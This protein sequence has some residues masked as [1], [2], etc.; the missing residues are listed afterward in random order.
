[1]S[2]ENFKWL[3][4][5]TFK[6]TDADFE[7]SDNKVD[8]ILN[9]KK[10]SVIHGDVVEVNG[11][12]KF[13]ILSGDDIAVKLILEAK[14]RHFL[15]LHMIFAMTGAPGVMTLPPEDPKVFSFKFHFIIEIL[16][17][18]VKQRAQIEEAK[19]IP[20]LLVFLLPS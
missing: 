19:P 20:I 2:Y 9:N 5:S 1:M 8:E 10:V 15:K 13:G 4:F 17:A 14:Q 18:V 6:G 7:I 16:P 12:K 11:S 3:E